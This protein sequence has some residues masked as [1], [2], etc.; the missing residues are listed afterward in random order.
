[1]QKVELTKARDYVEF[2]QSPK[3]LQQ[4]DEGEGDFRSA[5]KKLA[6]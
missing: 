4:G 3:F 5:S 6:E 2:R 1:V